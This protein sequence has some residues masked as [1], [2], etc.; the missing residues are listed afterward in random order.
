MLLLC[1]GFHTG[2]SQ[3]SAQLPLLHVTIPLSAL[4]LLLVI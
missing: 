4:V 3:L 1:V 2:Y